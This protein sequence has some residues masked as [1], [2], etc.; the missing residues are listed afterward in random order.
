MVVDVDKRRRDSKLAEHLMRLFAKMA[1]S[2][3]VKNHIQL[4]FRLFKTLPKSRF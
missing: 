1:P 2:A 3:R 4:S